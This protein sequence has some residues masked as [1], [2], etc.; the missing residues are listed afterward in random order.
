MPDAREVWRCNW[1]A[2]RTTVAILMVM[3]IAFA[4]GGEPYEMQPFSYDPGWIG[5]RNRLLPRE[6]RPVS[7]DFGY[8][9]TQRAG[10][11]A[12]GEIGGIVQRSPTPAYYAHRIA[13]RTLDDSL[14]ASGKLAVP[15]AEDASGVMVGWFKATPPSWR[16]PNS[17]AFRI[18]GN[19]G[20]FWMFYEYG[21]SGYRT[22]G[23]GAFEGPQYQ[24][25][26][27]AP[28]PADGKVHEWT[29][30]YDP[31]AADGLGL[32]TF[33]VDDRVYELPLAPGHRQEGAIF[34]HFGIWNVQT[35]GHRV[36]IYLDD[37]TVD[38]ESWSFDDDPR[39]EAEGTP[40]DFFERVLRPFHD[41]GYSQTSFAGGNVGEVGGIIFR[42]EQ[43]SYFGAVT[44]CLSLED[45]LFASGRLAL[46]MAAS[47]SGVY[48]G[49]FNGET[50][51]SN[52]VPEYARRQRDYLGILIE[53][54][55]RV[56]HYFRPGYSTTDGSGINAGED[57]D[58][59]WPVLRPNGTTHIWSIHYLPARQP[60]NGGQITITLDE[61]A[62]TFTVSGEDRQK[63]ARFDRFGLFNMQSGGHGV[64]LYLDDVRYTGR[65]SL[66]PCRSSF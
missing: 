47:D 48:L 16:T 65:A 39:W 45:E 52:D 13:T 4:R 64:E 66:L 7:Q 6:R 30:D 15:I 35:P 14:H 31:A 24:T 21:T 33:R 55:S 17:L 18:D 57:H 42:D 26:P 29:L 46:L 20:K 49:W 3:Q 54:P 60:Q 50:K 9:V 27:T 56:G 62:E 40:A 5:F 63:G 8:R 10:G 58:H 22:G 43:P 28:F 32:V 1:T 36:E 38:G 12:A 34:D 59:V 44:R 51:E 25:T 41:F 11:E 53:G 23:G 37:I 19:N 2:K 61:K